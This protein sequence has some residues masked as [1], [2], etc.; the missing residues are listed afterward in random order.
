MHL[1]SVALVGPD[2]PASGLDHHH[3]REPRLWPGS[4]LGRS[5][6]GGKPDGVDR[7]GFKLSAPPRHYRLIRSSWTTRPSTDHRMR[8]LVQAPWVAA[9]GYGVE[10]TPVCPR[11]TAGLAGLL[12]T[13]S[14]IGAG[15]VCSLRLTEIDKGSSSGSAAASARHASCGTSRQVDAGLSMLSASRWDFL[16]AKISKVVAAGRGW[17]VG[18]GVSAGSWCAVA[19]YEETGM[20]LL[21]YGTS[22]FTVEEM[23]MHDKS[24]F[25][26][27]R[28]RCPKL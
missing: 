12:D 26:C 20:M 7:S 2:L 14:I 6:R 9:K 8:V 23:L 5:T 3:D 27:G 25:P 11:A 21:S 10:A 13:V 17:R 28:R 24:P 15:A 18:A 16:P 1:G 22:T 4:R 19:R